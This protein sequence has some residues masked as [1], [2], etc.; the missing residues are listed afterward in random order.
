MPRPESLCLLPPM[1]EMEKAAMQQQPIS[2]S[3]EQDPEPEPA[4]GGDVPYQAAPD[5][6][7]NGIRVRN[8]EVSFWECTHDFPNCLMSCCCPCISI[9]QIVARLGWADYF[10]IVLGL[11]LCEFAVFGLV[12]FLGVFILRVRFRQTFQIP[13]NVCVDCCAAFWCGC[14][15]IAQMSTHVGS[16]RR[17]KCDFNAPTRLPGYTQV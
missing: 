4:R 15:A 13:G 12:T 3:L 1:S 6:D 17:G 16:Y 11:Y 7:H 8:W 10:V 2:V 9:G 14:C 5:V